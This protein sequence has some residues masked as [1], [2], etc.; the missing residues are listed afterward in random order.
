MKAEIQPTAEI[1]LEE[2]KN[3]LQMP[4]RDPYDTD[5]KESVE[6]PIQRQR[7][8]EEDAVN[9]NSNGAK[10]RTVLRA[11]QGGGQVVLQ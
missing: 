2:H 9:R 6:I 8:K 11:A 7:G 3:V 1:I 5:K 10:N 4:K